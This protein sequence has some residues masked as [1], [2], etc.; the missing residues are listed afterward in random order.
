MALDCGDASAARSRLIGRAEALRDAIR[1]AFEE[2][3]YWNAH[4]RQPHELRI[5]PDPDG[6][7]FGVLDALERFI[8]EARRNERGPLPLLRLEHV[9]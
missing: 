8:A 3:E 5:D 4:V 2:A 6:R 9:C 1:D 7:L